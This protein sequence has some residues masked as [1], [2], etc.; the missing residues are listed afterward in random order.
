MQDEKERVALTSILASGA[1]T[2]SKFI[3]GIMSGSLGVLSEAIH[4]LLDLGATALTYFAVRIS[5]KPAD[6]THHYGH[7]KVESVA[8]L[9]ETGLLFLTS[10]W[11]VYEAGKRLLSGEFEV[12]ASYWAIG[13]IIASIVIDFFRARALNRVAEK[14]GSQALAA[15]ALHFSSDM[16]SSAVVLLGLGFVWLGWPQADAIAAVGVAVFVCLAGW[17]LGRRTIDTLIDAAPEGSVDRIET[18]VDRIPGVVAIEQLRVRPSGPMLF[19]ELAIAV[20][21]TLPL[22]RVS[23]LSSR[24][25]EEIASGMPEAEVTVV[26]HPRALDDE[27]VMERVMVIARNRGLAV[28]HVTVQAIAADRLSVS[29]DLELDGR[30]PLAEAHRIASEL[31]FAVEDEL[32]S[33]VE[34]ETHIEPLQA[35][36]LVGEDLDEDRRQ[37]MEAETNELAAAFGITDVH[38]LRARATGDGL[39]VNFHCRIDPALSVAEVHDAVDGLERQIRAR[40]PDIH[41]VVGHA[42]PLR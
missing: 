33:E 22:D 21:R 37:R 5:G 19:V 14:T 8:A 28:H 38:H 1:L 32:G 17:R 42:E 9:I 16:L 20:G 40:W 25:R 15:D 36:G 27:T 29:L 6:D 4:S 26:T 24:I 3:V 41:R 39:I 31:E 30:M 11:I 12:E 7:A 34:V 23:Q 35:H 18:I 13:V 2:V 10:A